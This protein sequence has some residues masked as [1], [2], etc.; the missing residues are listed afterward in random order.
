[1]HFTTIM[2]NLC[3]IFRF[4]RRRVWR[5]LSSGMLRRVVWKKLTDVSY[6]FTVMMEAFRSSEMS[7]RRKVPGGSH[8]QNLCSYLN[9]FRSFWT[10]HLMHDTVSA[11]ELFYLLQ[12]TVQAKLIVRYFCCGVSTLLYWHTHIMNTAAVTT[13][14]LGR[15]K[16]TVIQLFIALV[17]SKAVGIGTIFSPKNRDSMCF[18]F[19]SVGICLQVHNPENQHRHLTAVK[20]SNLISE[21]QVKRKN[22]TPQIG[23][24]LG[25]KLNLKFTQRWGCQCWSS[26]LWRREDLLVDIRVSEK[27]TAPIFRMH[28]SQQNDPKGRIR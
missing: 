3:E 23:S 19:W 2:K 13:T 12:F 20:T 16:T 27:H 22:I 11:T 8:I 17:I 15:S 10:R 6:V 7:A 28:S 26:G 25:R 5:W 18:F 4:S 24:K 1:M 14:I 21:Q 9:K